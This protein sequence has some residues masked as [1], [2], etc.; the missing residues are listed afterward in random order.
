MDMARLN[1]QF[2]NWLNILKTPQYELNHSLRSLEFKIKDPEIVEP[3]FNGIDISFLSKGQINQ[4]LLAPYGSENIHTYWQQQNPELYATFRS[5]ENSLGTRLSALLNLDE[6]RCQDVLRHIIS[7]LIHINT[8]EK[9]LS[10]GSLAEQKEYFSTSFPRIVSGRPNS[11]FK[12]ITPTNALVSLMKS[13][14][15]DIAEAAKLEHKTP[16]EN[17]FRDRLDSIHTIQKNFNTTL[18]PMINVI[19]NGLN[20]TLEASDFNSLGETIFL[21]PKTLRPLNVLFHHAAESQQ[22]FNKISPLLKILIKDYTD[23]EISNASEE[24]HHYIKSNRSIYSAGL[25]Q[26]L[27]TTVMPDNEKI[28]SIITDTTLPHTYSALMNNKVAELVGPDMPIDYI[29]EATKTRHKHADTDHPFMREPESDPKNFWSDFKN[30]KDEISKI[31]DVI[32]YR[33]Y[34]R[35]RNFDYDAPESDAYTRLM[36]KEIAD[37]IY[38]LG[39]REVFN[40]YI[41]ESQRTG[42]TINKITDTNPVPMISTGILASKHWLKKS[43][44]DELTKETS[45][46]RTL[47]DDIYLINDFAKEIAPHISIKG[48]MKPLLAID[49]RVERMMCQILKKT[50]SDNIRDKKDID[51]NNMFE[52]TL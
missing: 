20:H 35:T 46:G 39:L 32:I 13:I 42:K 1:E 8:L 38:G 27:A 40:A 21:L 34:L 36:I 18:A 50:T 43:Y 29:I 51:V 49:N 9:T 5:D 26:S 37:C 52:N 23:D 28:I 31:A 30:F 17:P 6:F 7:T 47:F 25:Q 12:Y 15:F 14:Q 11:G 48:N 16:T 41:E 3:L 10:E 19:E 33:H 22:G 24:I 45:H 44:L 4:I 2:N